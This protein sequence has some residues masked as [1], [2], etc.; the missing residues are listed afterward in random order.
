MTFENLN[1]DSN[2]DCLKNAQEDLESSFALK[3]MKDQLRE[4]DFKTYWEKGRTSENCQEA[5]SF[6]GQSVT[7]V[8]N[9]DDLNKTIEVYK[10][11][12]PFSPKY[13]SHITIIKFLKSAGVVK[14]TPIETINPLH[15]DFYKSDDFNLDKINFVKSTSLGDV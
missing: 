2:C 4:N 14:S 12:F 15:Y 1:V 3:T 7:I 5:C 9:E 8:N 6:K 11:L 10:K 13:K